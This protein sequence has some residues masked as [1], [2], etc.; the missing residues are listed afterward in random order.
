M[1]IQVHYKNIAMSESINDFIRGELQTM[2][3]SIVPTTQP[4]MY[5]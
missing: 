3:K 5:I 1:K 4:W 2:L